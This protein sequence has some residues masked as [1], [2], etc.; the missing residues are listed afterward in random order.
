MEPIATVPNVVDPTSWSI[1]GRIGIAAFWCVAMLL[2]SAGPA[3]AEIPG[4]LHLNEFVG[5][6]DSWDVKSTLV[7]GTSG[8]ILVDSQFRIS[9]AKKLRDEIAATGRHLKAIIVTHPDY[10]H[11]IGT[12]VLRERFP[13]TP[14]YMTADAL[15]EFK[16]TSGDALSAKKKSIRTGM[17][18]D[19]L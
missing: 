16:R 14:T 6:A 18:W 12:A 4:T 13:E 11:Y 1:P 5:E 9:R 17:Q 3:L 19:P 10:D 15:E 7:Y 2:G 8:A